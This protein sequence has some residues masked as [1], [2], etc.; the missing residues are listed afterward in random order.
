MTLF[1]ALLTRLGSVEG[2][3]AAAQGMPDLVAAAVA[4][5]G[6]IV[7]P[8]FTALAAPSV[9]LV[10]PP[11]SAISRASPRR[12]AVIGTVPK[13]LKSAGPRVAGA[14]GALYARLQYMGMS[15]S[16]GGNRVPRQRPGPAASDA[17]PSCGGAPSRC[18]G[19][20]GFRCPHRAVCRQPPPSVAGGP[21]LNRLT[22]FG[23]FSGN[24]LPWRWAV[25]TRRAHPSVV[26]HHAAASILKDRNP[27][28]GRRPEVTAFKRPSAWP[29]RVA[30]SRC[31]SCACPR[32]LQPEPPGSLC[33][34]DRG[35]EWAT[36]RNISYRLIIVKKI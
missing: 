3:G 15:L 14:A 2:L 34:R 19:R 4:H 6:P 36:R 9:V 22:C 16:P 5:S 12:T 17:A 30:A 23:F 18:R 25:R 20:P 21:D 33:T 32:G 8:V 7:L 1:I 24:T 31:P 28:G 13:V 10:R 35:E 29:R 26:F 11:P 27:V